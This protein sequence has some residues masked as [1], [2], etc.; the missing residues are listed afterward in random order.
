MVTAV[1]PGSGLVQNVQGIASPNSVVNP[2][3][4]FAATR[5][6]RFPMQTKKNINALG[7]QDVVTLLQDG[8]VAA[9]E[10]RVWG[11]ITFG[12]TLG[13]TTMSYDYPL[14][15]ANFAL[16]AN[17]QAQLIQARGIVIRAMEYITNPKIEDSGIPA[18]YGGTAITSGSMKFPTDDWGTNASNSLNPGTNVP[19]AAAYTVDVSYFVPIAADQRSLVGSLFAQ[20]AASNLTLTIQWAAQGAVAGGTSTIGLVSAMGASATFAS[21]LQY[22]VIGLAYAIPIVNNQPVLPDLSVFHGLQEQQYTGLGG[23]INRLPLSGVGVGRTLLRLISQVTTGSTATTP[24]PV[25]DTN[26]TECSWIYGGATKPEAF[27][28][29]GSWN[30]YAFRATGVNLGKSWGIGL[31]DF[32]SDNALRDVIDEGSTSSLAIQLGLAAAPTNGVAYVTQETLFSGAVG[33]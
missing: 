8:I 22:E 30:N 27:P 9:L 1:N 31:W 4:F 16:A 32:A 33:A 21:S 3:A 29:G 19:A 15:L 14:N 28:E 6:Q 26:Y 11:T 20:T 12:G 2:A 13:T 25:N 17:G 5:R 7:G 24:L 10:V 18:S 23:T